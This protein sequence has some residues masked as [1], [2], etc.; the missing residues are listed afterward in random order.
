MKALVGII[1]IVAGLGIGGLLL[2]GDNYYSAGHLGYSR[3]YYPAF[4]TKP[5][6]VQY[7]PTI[8]SL[9]IGFG[10]GIFLLNSDKKKED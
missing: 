2:P 8:M 10:I 5:E 4:S 7:V 9:V 3:T 1:S 6:P